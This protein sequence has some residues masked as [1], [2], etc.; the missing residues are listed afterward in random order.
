MP[1]LFSGKVIF[2]FLLL[3]VLDGTVLPGI[4]VNGAYPSFLCLL[5]CYSAFEWGGQ[6]TVYVAFWAGLLRDLLSPGPLGFEAGLCV[7][8]AYALSFTVQKIEREFPGIYFLITFLYLLI[9]GV[10]RLLCSGFEGLPEAVSWSAVGGIALTALYSAAFLPLFYSITDG[11]MGKS[12]AKQ[13]ELF[14]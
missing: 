2:Y 1:R 12:H 5:I 3:F 10:L 13:Y 14:R 9:V 11:W 4:Q 8:L 6:K 7:L